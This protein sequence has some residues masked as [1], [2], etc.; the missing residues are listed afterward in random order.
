MAGLKP[1]SVSSLAVRLL[2]DRVSESLIGSFRTLHEER[3]YVLNLCDFF[4]WTVFL[5]LTF[6]RDFIKVCFE[7][8]CSFFKFAP[9][10]FGNE[11][12]F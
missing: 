11:S 4:L 9:E 12:K 7:F 8:F 1:V 6:G 2:V 10:Y 5:G 3:V